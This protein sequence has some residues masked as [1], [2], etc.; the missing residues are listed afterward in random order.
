MMERHVHQAATDM[1]HLLSTLECFGQKKVLPGFS[2]VFLLGVMGRD[3]EASG[4]EENGISLRSTA[5]RREL[6]LKARRPARF[7]WGPVAV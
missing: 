4:K 3:A 1:K 6:G 7:S 5:G 2:G